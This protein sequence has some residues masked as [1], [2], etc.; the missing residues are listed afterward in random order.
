MACCYGP[1]P[2]RTCAFALSLLI[3][4]GCALPVLEQKTQ[5]Y[6]APD[7]VTTDTRLG[8]AWLSKRQTNPDLSGIHPL[9]DAHDAFTARILLTGAAEQTLDIQYYIWRADITGTLLLESLL[10]AADRG[11]RVRLLLDDNGIRGMDDALAALAEQPNIHIR[12]FNPFV[13]RSPKWLGYITD[14][15]RLNRRM[16]NKSFTADNQVTIIGGRNIGDEYFGATDG[17]LFSDLDVLAAG[18]VVDEVSA[19]FDKYWNSPFS[20][21]AQTLLPKASGS[22]K[23]M[24]HRLKQQQNA[25][26]AQ[27]YLEAIENSELTEQI[28]DGNLSLLWAPTRMIS[29]PPGKIA[30]KAQQRAMLSHQ[31]RNAIGEPKTA[32][33]LISPYFVP[34][35][36]GLDY[37]RNLAGQGIRVRILTN[38]LEATDVAAVH[39]G[40]AGY[41][42]PLIKAGVELFEMRKLGSDSIEPHESKR[43]FGNSG[44]SLHAKTFIVDHRD[45]FIGSFNF[46]PRSINLNTELGFV[47]ESEKLAGNME[48]EISSLL[49]SSSYRVRLDSRDRLYWVEQNPDGKT[50]HTKEPY[51]SAGIRTLV[52]LMSLLPLEPLL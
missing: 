21:P 36:E 24:L 34:T 6:V 10:S 37:F 18:A 33:T 52:F 49:P 51:T 7:H 43:P 32:L 19:D 39:S 15:S 42:K 27:H 8:R 11:V 20:Y 14:F 23:H 13:V 22:A 50:I 4:A 46:D 44:S 26:R 28:V 31:L 9:A 35:A 47:I 38:S 12:L 3:L 29:D 41:R 40:Y 2:L 17:L 1:E 5:H 25:A 45:V 30:D 16:H 48:R